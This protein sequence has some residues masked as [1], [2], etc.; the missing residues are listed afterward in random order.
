[1]SGEDVAARRLLEGHLWPREETLVHAIALLA[2]PI[3]IVVL[4]ATADSEERR[5]AL[6]RV[7]WILGAGLVTWGLI[8]VGVEPL[9]ALLVALAVSAVAVIACVA[10]IA[11]RGAPGAMTDTARVRD[12]IGRTVGEARAR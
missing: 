11:M 7:I 12:L 2:L 9:R 8:A 6:P 4:I 5:T 10:A 1:M 3:L